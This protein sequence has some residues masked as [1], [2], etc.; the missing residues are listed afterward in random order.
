MADVSTWHPQ[1]MAMAGRW[2]TAT[3]LLAG[4]L[5]IKAGHRRYLPI[6]SG[7]T[8][9]Q[10][11]SY[12]TRAALHPAY[13]KTVDALRGVVLGRP[14]IVHGVSD[15]VRAWIEEDIT[16]HG[17]GLVEV[18]HWLVTQLLT[19]GRAGVLVDRPEAGGRPYV[20]TVAP[21][22]LI[23][24]REVR[25]EH[26]PAVLALAVV[27]E[28]EDRPDASGFGHQA[29]EQ[30]RVLAL[31]EGEY[32]VTLWGAS[33]RTLVRDTTKTPWSV[34]REV[35][36]VRRGQTMGFLPL[37]VVNTTG[38]GTAVTR[39][40]LEDLGLLV[41]SHYMNSADAEH[42]LHLVALPTPWASGVAPGTSTLKIGPGVAWMLEK[43]GRAGMLEFTGAGLAA[44]RESMSAKERQMAIVGG[45]LLLEP[46]H[47][48]ANETAT[49]AKLRNSAESS[50]LRGIADATSA[51][52]TN[53][54]RQVLWWESTNDDLDPDVW[55]EVGRDF[56]QPVASP[57][58]VKTL[59]L[60]LQSGSIS[61]E[62]FYHRL[63]AGG[64]AREGVTSEQEQEDIARTE[65]AI[66]AI[67]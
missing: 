66:G 23:N 9:E 41:L 40:P 30:Y 34:I 29:H 7:M 52:L 47:A 48:T 37:T 19:K 50:S 60:L 62:S 39:A 59:L 8:L 1:A 56:F 57:E 45:R 67:E 4:E 51:A 28:W 35:T 14:P 16:G 49:S 55:V 18:A 63:R 5:A 13:A 44:F 31:D 36:P 33:D 65:T 17:V 58:E 61:Y 64:W 21:E 24:W 15:E 22:D 53:A 2:Q 32:R 20:V 3:D 27:R 54:V 26:D 12:R 38:L 43:D 10:Y 42:G 11:D 25:T 46:A 6:P